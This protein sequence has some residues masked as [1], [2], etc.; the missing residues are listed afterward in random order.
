MRSVYFK[1][2]AIFVIIGLIVCFENIQFAAP[3]II[4]FSYMGTKTIFFPLLIIMVIG[5]IGGLFAG[6][7]IGAKKKSSDDDDADMLDI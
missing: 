2:S 1:F 5:F 7:G 6:L 4:G 3:I